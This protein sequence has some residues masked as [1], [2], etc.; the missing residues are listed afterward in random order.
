[1]PALPSTKPRVNRFASRIERAIRACE[2]LLDV[3]ITTVDRGGVFHSPEGL[4]LLGYERQ[5]HKKNPVCAHG[6]T[7]E[8]CV[9][10]CRHEINAL[11]EERCEPFVHT[12][13]KGVQEVVV[14]LVRNGVH[15]GSL[16]AGIWRRSGT[17]QP[18]AA[19]H[20]P[21][22]AIAAYQA[23]PEFDEVRAQHLGDLLTIFA[24]G[25][26]DE[27]QPHLQGL[28]R[29]PARTLPQDLRHATLPLGPRFKGWGAAH[30]GL[31]SQA[32]LGRACSAQ[33]GAA[34][35]GGAGIPACP[36]FPAQTG[37]SAPPCCPLRS[38]RAGDIAI[39]PRC[40][41]FEA[42]ARVHGLLSISSM[43]SRYCRTRPIPQFKVYAICSGASWFSRHCLT[44]A[45]MAR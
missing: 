37:M 42:G 23:L 39:C 13:W 35:E 12:C 8:A 18:L 14:P 25:L 28:Y 2:K 16:F 15:F 21:P 6:F 43:M 36:S 5:S 20:L 45:N 1:M 10:H 34:V 41:V 32:R 31:A 26:L 4:A 38:L 11:G 29:H 9:G 19:D 40:L 7:D 44:R 30:L 3:S 17:T 22:A 33:G 24:Q 27:L